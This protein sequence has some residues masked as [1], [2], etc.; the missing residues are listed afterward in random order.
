MQRGRWIKKSPVS[1]VKQRAGNT[2][3]YILAYSVCSDRQVLDK[4]FQVNTVYNN[5]CKSS[6]K[7]NIKPRPIQFSNIIQARVQQIQPLSRP[8]PTV[9][10]KPSAIHNFR[11][12]YIYKVNYKVFEPSAHIS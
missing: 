3:Y 2:I 1:K 10:I 8:L 6:Q 9:G 7:P 12:I 4:I 11:K 5:S